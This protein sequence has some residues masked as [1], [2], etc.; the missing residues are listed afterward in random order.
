MVDASRQVSSGRLREPTVVRLTQAV[1]V[2]L[3]E[4]VVCVHLRVE[5]VLREAAVEE[6]VLVQLLRGHRLRHQHR[7]LQTGVVL[8]QRVLGRLLHVAH[9][10]L[11]R[12]ALRVRCRLRRR[13][14]AWTRR[15][16]ARSRAGRW[17]RQHFV[18]C[19]RRVSSRTV[20]AV[21]R[22]LSMRK[23][24]HRLRRRR[25]AGASGS[26]DRRER[27]LRATAIRP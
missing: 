4:E 26:A 27:V 16:F 12:T 2:L 23:I 25:R 7:L 3:V 22:S 9:R 1:H 17:R 15:H 5:E 13:H 20:H 18:I 24:A 11:S 8:R 10:L 19:E 6:E 21:A 14:A